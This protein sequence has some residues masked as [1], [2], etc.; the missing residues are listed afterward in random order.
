MLSNKVAKIFIITGVSLIAAILVIWQIIW[1][2]SWKKN[3][4]IAEGVKISGYDVGG[5]DVESAK[6]ML[7]IHLKNNINGTL[8]IYYEDIEITF[9]KALFTAFSYDSVLDEAYSMA[10]TGNPSADY[11]ALVRAELFGMSLEA[12]TAF[13]EDI[14]DEELAK[15]ADSFSIKAQDAQILS[16]DPSAEKGSRLSITPQANGRRLD[17][18]KTKESIKEAIIKG[19][20]RAQAY[21]KET[22][23]DITYEILAAMETE[24]VRSEYTINGISPENEA[25][26]MQAVDT[27]RYEII[28]PGEEISI[29]EFM[30]G[31][32]YI[33]FEMP[34]GG[35]GG[36]YE[37]AL[38][39]YFPTQIY[40][41][42]VLSELDV[43]ERKAH[44]IYSENL[45]AGTSTITDQYYDMKV[46]N[47]LSSPVIIRVGYEKKDGTGQIFCEVL[48][49][50]M[51]H[52]TLLRSVIREKE[53][54]TLVDITRVYVDNKG[55]TIDT[56]VADTVE[57]H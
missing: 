5:Y 21:V 11:A 23:A 27:G 35:N 36:D 15:A 2:S 16:F 40:I 6:Q 39:E 26:I 30:G 14:L 55:N 18:D 19:K 12:E 57:V 22:T 28:L 34:D 8:V 48:R 9:N 29:I 33:Y 52:K 3:T 46:K 1:F 41:A 38:T 37:K 31:E 43:T 4:S 7:D 53:N 17:I 51:E 45:P 10:R 44:D 56:V 50:V 13:A 20:D 25:A 24:P 49:P 32:D 54:K 47:T 42:C